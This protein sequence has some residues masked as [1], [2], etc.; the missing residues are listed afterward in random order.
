MKCMV[1]ELNPA[2][3]E[4]RGDELECFRLG[5]NTTL[6][7]ACVFVKLT[8]SPDPAFSECER[9][10]VGQHPHDPR[11]PAGA[12]MVVAPGST[13]TIHPTG[14]D[15]VGNGGFVTDGPRMNYGTQS[16][17]AASSAS[18]FPPE[19]STARTAL[20]QGSRVG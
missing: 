8:S 13:G 5:Q 3:G 11:I 20:A 7:T 17:R 2:G 6:R 14:G 19:S 9:C 16:G 15:I 4:R 18:P 1:G 10:F 12:V